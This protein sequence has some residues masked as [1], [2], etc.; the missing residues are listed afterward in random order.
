M[1]ILSRLKK[2]VC[3]CGGGADLDLWNPCHMIFSRHASILKKN[4]FKFKLH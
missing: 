3:V 2:N 4:L 1:I